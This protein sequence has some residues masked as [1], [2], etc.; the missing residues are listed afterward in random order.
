M[1]FFGD[2]DRGEE[3]VD[4]ASRIVTVTLADGA[5]VRGKLALV[6][7]APHPPAVVDVV[8]DFAAS[9]LATV[10]ADLESAGVPGCEARVVAAVRQAMPRR[11]PEVRTI[12]LAAV[13]VLEG[14][15]DRNAIPPRAPTPPVAPEGPRV[16][17]PPA[18]TR[19]VTPPEPPR[20]VT[21]PAGTRAVTPPDPPG[22]QLPKTARPVGRS[23]TRPA[24]GGPGSPARAASHAVVEG[25]LVEG[26]V[27]VLAAA[28]RDTARRLAIGALRAHAAISRRRA[29][30]VAM[31]WIAPLLPAPG[32]TPKR[33]A[34]ASELARW[35]TAHG[36]DVVTGVEREAAVV[37]AY[38]CFEALLDAGVGG[39]PAARGVE[40]ACR[41][42]FPD[43]DI[44]ARLGR[45]VF[46]AE[47]GIEGEVARAFGALFT[48][49][50][51]AVALRAALRPLLRGLRALS[52]GAASVARVASPGPRSR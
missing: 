4:R 47:H 8:V 23:G 29:P 34:W 1:G 51:E 27:G 49:S 43:L 5:V 16:M 48:P 9:F 7:E 20:V 36:A 28:A 26:S 21:P 6:F 38:L 18:G 11:F 17:T 40:L 15:A 22:P 31:A 32:A 12:P 13:H 33:E 24:A 35:R 45:Y 19:A 30:S 2:D 25:T 46:A 3:K 50:I 52:S 41:A 42:A 39:R 37:A 44:P 10:L 14:R